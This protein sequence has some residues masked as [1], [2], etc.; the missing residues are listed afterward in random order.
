[1]RLAKWKLLDQINV[2]SGTE[3]SITVYL[4]LI[5]LILLSLILTV[6]EG[7]RVNTAKINANR[8]LSVAMDSVLAEYYGPLWEE[9]HILGYDKGNEVP[10]IQKDKLE[11]KLSEYISLTL[12]PY[13]DNGQA[14][15]RE[16]VDLYQLSEIRTSVVK[17]VAVTDYSGK[18]LIKEAVDYMKYMETGEAL[19]DILEQWSLL[20]TPAKVSYLTQEKLKMEEELVEVDESILELMELLDGLDTGKQGIELTSGGKLKVKE[21]FVKMICYEEVTKETVGIN[22]PSVVEALRMNYLNP[23]DTFADINSRLEC[24]EHSQ[25]AIEM[26]EMQ[27][28][29]IQL[30]LVQALAKL[31]E[32]EVSGSSSEE[33]KKQKNALIKSIEQMY[34]LINEQ[35]KHIKSEEERIQNAKVEIRSETEKLNSVLKELQTL[36][37]KAIACMDKVQVK[38]RAVSPLLNQYEELLQ[39]N[40][41]TID[42][43]TFKGLEMN[44]DSMK[45]YLE[46]EEDGRNF[47]A[48]IKD[49]EE[50]LNI[51]KAVIPELDEALTQLSGKSYLE[52]G[53]AYHTAEQ[54]LKAYR[55]KSLTLDYSTMILDQQSQKSPLTAVDMLLKTNVLGLVTDINQLSTAKLTSDEALPSDAAQL[56]KENINFISRLQST[57]H[58]FLDGDSKKGTGELFADNGDFAK[59]GQTLLNTM[60]KAVK[61]YL[62]EEYLKEHY[63]SLLSERDQR[64]PSVLEYEQEY[65]LEGK[66]SDKENLAQVVSGVASLRTVINFAKLIGDGGAREEARLAAAAAVGFTGLPILV[67]ITQ[68]LILISWSYA[69]AL[70]DICALL[71]GKKLPVLKKEIVI[72]LSELFLINQSFLQQKA[73]TMKDTKVRGAGYQDYLSI[74]LFTKKGEKLSCRTMDLMQL[75]IRLRYQA[76]DFCISHCLFSYQAVAEY[77]IPSKFTSLPYVK[78]YLNGGKGDMYFSSKAEYSY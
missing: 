19:K 67:S 60:G 47:A 40:Q 58:N 44:L 43:E 42:A 34:K 12:D 20:E 36:S 41:D 54:L 63:A 21:N 13:N 61:G 51:L 48:M 22:H 37:M 14:S 7:A 77:K 32:Q 29:A 68:V 31:A 23:S 8:A 18:I 65:L 38:A 64:K 74:F 49:L 24:M 76:K 30:D 57:V 50:N 39:S 4:S 28:A 1:M 15:V 55:I 52:A 33:D 45:V 11:A 25:S 70:L 3:G 35:Q 72:K 59:L 9:Y 26:F 5:L 56:S 2:R 71:M 62:Y 6:I 46:T 75:N 10:D 78:E 16:G 66:K 53:K 73:M 17:E 69:E 27:L